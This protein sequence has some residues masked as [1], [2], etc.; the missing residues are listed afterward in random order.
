M[1][2]KLFF[3][4]V[5]NVLIVNL[6]AQTD[7]LGDENLNL[8][9]NPSFEEFQDKI[10]CNFYYKY[11][12]FNS[13]L[14]NWKTPNWGK[15]HVFNVLECEPDFFY[16][17]VEDSLLPHSGNTMLSIKTYKGGRDYQEYIQGTLSKALEKG[18]L[19]YVEFY[20]SRNFNAK[21]ASN[22]LGFCFIDKP[23]FKNDKG[24]IDVTPDFNLNKIIYTRK[25]EWIKVSKLVK[26]RSNSKYF[27][28]GNFSEFEKTE[29]IIASAPRSEGNSALNTAT[30]F[31]DDVS[32]VHSNKLSN[33]NEDGLDVVDY[34]N[35][36]TSC[37]ETENLIR[38]FQF[39]DYEIYMND[40]N[41]VIYSPLYWHYETNNSSH[42]IYFST[43]RFLNKSILQGN[44]HPDSQRI[45]QGDTLNYIGVP[46]LPK[47]EPVYSK[48]RCKLETGCYY[49][50][51]VKIRL[52]GYSNC[53]SDLLVDFSGYH[54]FYYDSI[55]QTI[56][57]STP[58]SIS[59][60]YLRDKWVNISTTFR[61]NGNEEYI[62]I[63]AN[64]EPEIKRIIL[65]NI[66]KFDGRNEYVRD[67]N[68]SYLI[69][70]VVLK[71]VYCADSKNIFAKL[72]SLEIG[73]SFILQN[74]QFDFDKSII[75]AQSFQYLD[76]LSEYLE[77]NSG[78]KILIIG[79]TDNIG[80]ESYNLDLSSMRAKAV[81][82]YLI[83]KGIDK[84][85]LDYK[86]VGFTQPLRIG[87]SEEDKELNRRVEIKL[88]E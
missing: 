7:S 78:M 70:S 20:I 74:I 22:N 42:P 57:L 71:K 73:D 72:D 40:N 80:T 18:K 27:I 44:T 11:Q 61:A 75:Q 19:Y 50:L 88:I 29:H 14:K 81:F 13:A 35:H 31:I 6:V 59:P 55:T 76:K 17:S 46:L 58:D 65:S 64:H 47:S 41:G 34:T 49:E 30:Y 23:T 21:Y 53:F 37:N 51:S 66:K 84:S 60:D 48:L 26:A 83:N 54:P 68:M 39:D 10:P 4:I 56:Q 69:D 12:E 82:E 28:I 25:G 45:L 3:V 79:H 9:L 32:V 87:D 16:S 15:P 38:N 1:I 63:G 67:F 85:R 62:V 33:E 77:Y 2:K 8:V 43:D 24:P 36:D 5:A 86:G 52:F